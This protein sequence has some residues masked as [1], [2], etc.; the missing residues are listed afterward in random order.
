MKRATVGVAGV[1]T[2]APSF[3]LGGQMIASKIV[4]PF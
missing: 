1:R 3:E 2:V 4:S